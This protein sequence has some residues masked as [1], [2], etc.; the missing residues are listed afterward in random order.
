[1]E[2]VPI[3]RSSSPLKITSFQRIRKILWSSLPVLTFV[4]VI[5]FWAIIVRV[6]TVPAYI[7]PDPLHVLVRL[8]QDASMV[9]EQSVVTMEEVLLGFAIVIVT[10][11]PLGLLIALSP[12]AKH[13]I[14]PGIVFLQLIPKIAIA[15]LFLVWLGFGLQ[16]K[17]LLTI[18]MTFF[19]LLLSSITG[20]SILDMRMLYI[21]RSMGASGWQTLRYL[22]FPSALTVIFSGLKTSATLAVTAAIVAEFV[23]SNNGLGYQLMQATGN[24]DTELIFAILLVLTALG[25]L[26]NYAVEF[27]EYILQ[28]WQRAKRD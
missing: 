10:A 23:G 24:M 13:V 4:A 15:P 27:L 25:L 21:T 6:F 17:L 28:P 7:L 9:W 12:T 18:L 16:S 8:Y 14:Y 20:F 3:E 5:V 26:L 2:S 1:M 11:I 22:R 19:P